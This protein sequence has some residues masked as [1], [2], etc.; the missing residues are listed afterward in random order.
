MVD[1]SCHRHLDTLG[2]TSDAITTHM[3]STAVKGSQELQFLVERLRQA[4]NAAFRERRHA[5]AL[6]YV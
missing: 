2:R 6:E 5:G 1:Q 4:A 3:V